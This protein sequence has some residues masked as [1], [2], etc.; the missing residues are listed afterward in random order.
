MK[1]SRLDYSQYD[2]MYLMTDEH[3]VIISQMCHGLKKIASQN[4]LQNTFHT[5]KI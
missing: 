4:L 2:G 1:I 3:D 5:K